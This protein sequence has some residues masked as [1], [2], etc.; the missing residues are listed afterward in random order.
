MPVLGRDIVQLRQ[1]PANLRKALLLERVGEAAFTT[2]EERD[3]DTVFV[4]VR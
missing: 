4:I 3:H 1:L 2:G